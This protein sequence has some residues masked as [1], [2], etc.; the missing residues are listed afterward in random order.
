LDGSKEN[1]ELK[2]SIAM[3]QTEKNDPS[4]RRES[5]KVDRATL[6]SCFS[7]FA[8]KHPKVY[9]RILGHIAIITELIAMMTPSVA[10]GLQWVTAL[11]EGPSLYAVI[12]L[13]T[14]VITCLRSGHCSFS[15]E[16]FQHCILRR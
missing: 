12:D 9:V 14:M 16:Q 11:C 3:L 6:D 1:M 8:R 5:Q 7:R 15:Q 10:L 13:L 2:A 4:F